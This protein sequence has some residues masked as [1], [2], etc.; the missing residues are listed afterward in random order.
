[1]NNRRHDV[2]LSIK[3]PGFLTF[4]GCFF[5]F[6]FFFFLISFHIPLLV[7]HILCVSFLWNSSYLFVFCVLILEFNFLIIS[8]KD[9]KTNNGYRCM[10]TSFVR[11]GG[12]LKSL[13][14]K[15]MFKCLP[16]IKWFY[17][18]I[19]CFLPQNGQLK[20]KKLANWRNKIWG[21]GGICS[22]LAPHLIRFNSITGWHFN[23]VLHDSQ[24]N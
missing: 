16:N 22:P 11:G 1:M 17:Q 18:N 14:K 7:I 2:L 19:T 20:K 3:Q 13:A 23:R 24:R 15:K 8:Y 9:V 10:G 12:G 6:S 5:P 4:A 21:G